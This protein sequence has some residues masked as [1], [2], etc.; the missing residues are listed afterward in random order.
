MADEH[1]DVTATAHR[2]L[3]VSALALLTA[4]APMRGDRAG[5][6]FPPGRRAPS[7]FDL[8]FTNPDI[9]VLNRTVRATASFD[10]IGRETIAAA[11]GVGVEYRGQYFLLTVH[12]VF[13]DVGAPSQEVLPLGL[14]GQPGGITCLRQREREYCPS[15]ELSLLA[16]P[17]QDIAVIGPFDAPPTAEILALDARAVQRR[18]L[19]PG[20]LMFSWSYPYG[21]GPSFSRSSYAYVQTGP[22]MREQV[23]LGRGESVDI[24]YLVGWVSPGESGSPLFSFAGELAGIVNG[25]GAEK[26]TG[27]GYLTAM[28]A[29]GF[30]PALTDLIS[31][32]LDSE[33]GPN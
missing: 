32:Y 6:E 4:C 16:L 24:V 33:I 29:W 8:E 12:H 7:A 31:A 27:I 21:F 14:T 30:V 15:E 26:D 1:G 19:I 18:E 25:G 11:S 22:L 10:V 13:R 3:L 28:P 5:D 17:D 2:P 9:R 23:P 20:Q